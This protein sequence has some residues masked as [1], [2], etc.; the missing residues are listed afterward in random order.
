MK[1]EG[2]PP[3]HVVITCSDTSWTWPSKYPRCGVAAALTAP[4]NRS[5]PSGM[6]AL[7]YRATCPTANLGCGLR[8]AA[9][10]SARGNGGAAWSMTA[11]SAHQVDSGCSLQA[12]D[13]LSC[14]RPAAS[15][16]PPATSPKRTATSA[17]RFLISATSQAKKPLAT[18]SQ[19]W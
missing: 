17:I 16:T 10:T 11:A 9:K 14:D 5:G 3:L 4:T 15:N 13:A 1:V 2:A 8:R 6:W 12:L 7:M 18:V 19:G